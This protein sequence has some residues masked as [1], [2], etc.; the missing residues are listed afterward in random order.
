MSV[1]VFISMFFFIFH[2]NFHFHTFLIIYPAIC[3]KQ[4]SANSSYGATIYQFMPNPPDKDDSNVVKKYEKG[5]R[6][7][8]KMQDKKEEKGKQE[9]TENNK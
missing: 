1:S 6:K 5:K 4:R 9:K 2:V 3:Y 7:R 8:V